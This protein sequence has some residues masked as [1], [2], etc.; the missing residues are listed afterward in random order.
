MLRVR[1]MVGVRVGQIWFSFVRI[2]LRVWSRVEVS[3]QITARLGLRIRF[4][5]AWAYAVV[6]CALVS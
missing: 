3:V 6:L 1:A 2:V 5:E 4:G